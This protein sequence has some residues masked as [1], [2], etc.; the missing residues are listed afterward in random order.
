MRPLADTSRVQH[1]RFLTHL[2]ARRPGSLLE[3]CVFIAV[4]LV[5]TPAFAVDPPPDA[6]RDG[7]IDADEVVAGT[8]AANP[9]TDGDGLTDGYEVHTTT[10]SPLVSDTDGGGVNDGVELLVQ[11]TNP[12]SSV[13]DRAATIMGVGLSSTWVNSAAANLTSLSAAESVLTDV[14]PVTD[15]PSPTQCYMNNLP[16]NYADGSGDSAGAFTSGDTRTQ[17]VWGGDEDTFVSVFSGY[18]FVPPADSENPDASYIFAPGAN[19]GLRLRIFDGTSLVEVARD[20]QGPFRTGQP[21]IGSGGNA[22]N[23][24]VIDFPNTGGLFPIELFGFANTGP[25]GIELSWAEDGTAIFSSSTFDLIPQSNFVAPDLRAVQSATDINGGSVVAGDVLEVLVR[26]TNSGPVPAYNVDFDTHLPS[27][28]TLVTSGGTPPCRT[29]TAAVGFCVPPNATVSGQHVSFAQIPVNHTYSVVYRV[30]VGTGN[31]TTAPFRLQGVVRAS[32]TAETNIGRNRMIKLTDDPVQGVVDSGNDPIGFE[33]TV[34]FADGETDDDF[35]NIT[36]DIRNDNDGDGLDYDDEQTAG[37]DPNNPDTDGGGTSDGA[38]IINGT[39][40]LDPTDDNANDTDHDGLSD[41]AEDDYNTDPNDPDTDDDGLPDGAEVAIGSDPLDPDTDGD[42]LKDGE[43]DVNHN[44]RVDSNETSPVKADTD[45]DG[46]TDGEEKK[47]YDTNPLDPDTDDGGRA[48]GA[49]ITAGTDPLD[50]T[51]D[52]PDTGEPP[53]VP[54]TTPGDGFYPDNNGDGFPDNY[55]VSGGG[56]AGGPSNPFVGLVMLA[57][58]ALLTRGRYRGLVLAIAVMVSASAAYAQDN[59]SFAPERMRLAIDGNGILD[60]EYGKIPKHLEWNVGLLL[61]FENDMLVVHAT[62]QQGNRQRIGSLIGTRTTAELVG[63]IALWDRLELGLS[64]PV[65]LQQTNDDIPGVQL[66]NLSGAGIGDLRL[67][68]K[69]ELV[70]QAQIG[71]DIAVMLSVTLP[72]GGDSAYRGSDGVTAAPELIVSRQWGIVRT[73]FNVGYLIRPDKDSIDLRVANEL[74]GRLGLAIRPVHV[75][76]FGATSSVFTQASHPF[77]DRNETALEVD[78]FAQFYVPYD[79]Q[80]FAGAGAGITEG[81]GTPDYRVFAGI[82]Y[83]PKR[84]EPVPPP[85]E[86]PPPPLPPSDRDGDGI[87]DDK[88][89]CPDVPETVNGFEDEDGC[90]D[91]PPPPPPPEPIAAPVVLDRD[92]DGV[93]DAVDNCPDVPGSP[94]FQ[95]C[96][97]AQRVRIE[98]DRLYITETVRFATGKSLIDKRS[99]PLLNNIAAVLNAH[100][101]IQ[102]IEIAGHTDDVGSDASNLVLSQ[103]RSAA[104]VTYLQKAGVAPQRMKSAGYGESR[105]VMVA[106]TPAARAMN[107]RVEFNIVHRDGA[108]PS[109]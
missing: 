102:E 76:E 67:V 12:R 15:V 3:A 71:L 56:C 105:P 39:N 51:D 30:T 79:I 45:T 5:A 98:K 42:G 32:T 96:P 36:T 54:P 40:P 99:Y 62:D 87:I 65:I 43:E 63:A 27:G 4:S 53:T 1:D 21:G 47:I 101:E 8:N 44:G 58:L 72:T 2:S 7:L 23:L 83:A 88:D 78:G 77:T 48:D 20:G 104:V 13:D 46:L 57:L 95:G 70:N 16:I 107:R 82:R 26:I 24:T 17:L 10:T 29:L 19:D 85:V 64:L 100:P 80:L 81:F 22:Q 50:P 109:P 41:D 35:T 18:L 73:A 108:S 52:I 11:G 60:V 91:E 74:Y 106:T 92:G 61:N 69:L 9:D 75:F 84:A 66:A 55:D 89:A 103:K 94:D 59:R 33:G 97:E 49:E 38:E 68:P 25:W 37:T 93:P 6:D 31:L 14:E 28:L 90:P 34:F 86:A